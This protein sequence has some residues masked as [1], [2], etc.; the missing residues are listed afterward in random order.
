VTKKDRPPADANASSIISID[1]SL[2][3]AQEGL[4]IARTLRPSPR[5]CIIIDKSCLPVL[6]APACG[7][8]YF[9][10]ARI[11]TSRLRTLQRIATEHASQRSQLHHVAASPRPRCCASLG[12]AWSHNTH[13]R[14]LLA[15]VSGTNR[16]HRRA[17]A[18]T[19]RASISRH[20]PRTLRTLGAID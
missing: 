3:S 2:S 4:L 13:C 1:R 6:T 18:T 5:D 7:F 11:P 20:C 17:A 15:E 19:F 12:L 8:V 14:L 9:G 16:R 10:H